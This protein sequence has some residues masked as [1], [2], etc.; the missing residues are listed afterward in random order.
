MFNWI[1]P[2]MTVRSVKLEMIQSNGVS[3][4][5]PVVV[6]LSPE[7]ATWQRYSQNNVD[8]DPNMHILSEE[9]VVWCESSASL[10]LMNPVFVQSEGYWLKFGVVKDIVGMS[11]CIESAPT[12]SAVTWASGAYIVWRLLTEHECS[13]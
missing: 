2:L 11:F 9:P 8:R 1:R 13:G 12:R 7:L 4:T 10:P 3:C 6:L 5:Q